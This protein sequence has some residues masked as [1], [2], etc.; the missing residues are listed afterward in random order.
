MLVAFHACFRLGAIAAPLR[1][2]F[3]CAELGPMLQRLAP[4]LYIGEPAFYPNIAPVDAAILG[5]NN[6]I[7]IDAAD[8]HAARPWDVLKQA[9][10]S[11]D[12]PSPDV[13]EPALLIN[14]S[15]TTGQS[16]F[17]VHTLQTIAA[18]AEMMG[19]NLD[20]SPGD[21]CVLSSGMAHVGGLFLSLVFIRLGLPFVVLEGFEAGAVLDA[22]ERHHGSWMLAFPSQFAALVEQQKAKRRDI[23]SLRCCIIAGDTCPA[24]LQ[25][26]FASAL[27]TTLRNMWGGTEAVGT[28]AVMSQPGP[29]T[30][31]TDETLIRLVDENGVGV[32]RRGRRTPGAW[33]QCVDWILERSGDHRA[34]VRRR[35]VAHWRSDAARSRRRTLVRRAQERHHHSR[36]S[37][38]LAN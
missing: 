18:N 14:T 17:V 21:V 5:R 19:R 11:A 32:T 1:T 9:G 10:A 28:V 7:L 26:Q 27:G 29:V 22:V 36:R 2:A 24:D 13:S 6:R 4:A 20:L 23:S 30:K 3:T 33:P 25:E 8:G 38:D 34:D 15:G 31:I 37:Q 12:V 16:K 35:L